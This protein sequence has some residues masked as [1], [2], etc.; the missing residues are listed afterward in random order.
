M[1]I[2]L[3]W[4][5]PT[6]PTW[7]LINRYFGFFAN[8]A[9]AIVFYIPVESLQVCFPVVSLAYSVMIQKTR[10]VGVPTSPAVIYAT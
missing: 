9:L 3:V 1:E 5:R 6:R 4:K 8:L 2:E 10:S 7:F